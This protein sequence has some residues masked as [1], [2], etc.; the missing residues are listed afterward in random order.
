MLVQ[1]SREVGGAD[2]KCRQV[3]FYLEP[4]LVPAALASITDD[5]LPRF[6]ALPHFRGYVAMQSEDRSRREIVVTSFWDDGLA[7]S[8]EASLAFVEAVQHAAGTNPARRT[9]E[10][11]GAVV[12]DPSGQE[13]VD[14]T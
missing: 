2:V 10:V 12:V 3:S 1:V 11:L 4:D 14:L 8:E 13:P 6:L 9:F 7:E 5:V